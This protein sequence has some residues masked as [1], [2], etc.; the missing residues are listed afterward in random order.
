M[1]RFELLP[2]P[3]CASKNTDVRQPTCTRESPYDPLDRA[4]P[5][6]RCGKCYAEISGDDFDSSCRTAVHKWNLRNGL[7][8]V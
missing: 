6:V 2:C 7:V 8:Q 4:Y 3:F 5:I 1:N